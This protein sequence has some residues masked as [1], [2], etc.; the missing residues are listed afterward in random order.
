M[1][2]LPAGWSDGTLDEVVDFNPRHEAGLDMAQ[3]VSFVPMPGVSAHTGTI[4]G[5]EDRPLASVWK[6]FTHF[7]D[8][9]VIFA[10]ITPCMENG[11]I[12][13][14]REL[15]NGIACGSTEFHVLRSRG[16]VLPEFVWRF[17]R[18][19]SF[20]RD[21]EAAMTGAVGQRR[22]PT[23]YL[24][25]SAL[26]VPPL[27]EQRRIV[28]KLDALTARTARARADLDRVPALAARYKQAVLARAFAGELTVDWRRQNPNSISE[29]SLR[30]EVSRQ[31]EARRKAEGVRSTGANRSVPLGDRELPNIPSGWTWMTFDECSW[32]STVGHVG[33]MKDRYVEQGT[34]FL[35]SLNVK[36]NSIR[37]D[38]LVSIAPEFHRELA[39]SRLRA[40]TI[41]VV[42]TGEPGVAAVIP[43]ELD[44][45]NCSDLVICRPVDCLNPHYGARYINSDFAKLFVYDN[46]VGVAQQHFNV[47]AMS[48]LPVPFAPPAEQAEIV[49]VIDRSFTEIDR[50]TAEATSARHLLHR[51]DQAILSKAFRGELV[52]Q[53][54]TDEPAS[55][56]LEQLRVQRSGAPAR[57]RRERRPKAA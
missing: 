8:G 35:R 38:Y 20:R 17:L 53:D 10:K 22:V 47:G 26:P 39:K 15:T 9:D 21:A 43:A 4:D 42:R 3:P 56:L 46:Q 7:A 51:L 36:V 12:A 55:V 57:A 2:N 30:R 13:V 23:D 37:K 33:P 18:Q 6:G 1:S 44:N 48:K 34:P 14:A 40:G 19:T 41:V 11:K 45:S 16:G 28:A 50:L 29:Q 31:R 27:A 25:Q 24:R 32:D 49:R 52:P 5:A 54:P